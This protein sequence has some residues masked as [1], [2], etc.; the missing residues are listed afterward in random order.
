VLALGGV[1]S[2]LALVSGGYRTGWDAVEN[3]PSRLD[4]TIH[5][6]IHDRGTFAKQ[7]KEQFARSTFANFSDS[8][9][10]V[11]ALER[12]PSVKQGGAVWI[13]GDDSPLTMMLGHSWPYYFND[14][15]DTSP[16]GFQKQVLARL[17]RTPPARVVWN[18]R[19]DALV[20]DA[21]PMPVRVPLLYEWALKNLAP[22]QRV[23]H[24]EI[25]RDR[26]TGEPVPLG[27]WRERLG[28]K[29]D[30]GRIPAVASLSGKPCSTGPRCGTFV[31]VHF[32]PNTP[33]PPDTLLPMSVGGV[34]FD[35]SF[36]PGR[37]SSYVIPLDRV[38]FWTSAAGR[39]RLVLAK[40]TPGGPQ[41]EIVHRTIDDSV[42][43]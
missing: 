17:K 7:A 35:V 41:I 40:T 36:K 23:G 9:P 18:F 20:Y 42:L 32:A 5:G 26:R 11:H 19:P 4:G 10:V 13:L 6:L 2:A 21:V 39:S 30:L 31:V 25:L 37:E 34:R 33:K 27:W 29:L 1:A 3:G 28:R 38:W 24:F 43:Y 8:W 22:E 16:I 14:T 12:V 15:Y